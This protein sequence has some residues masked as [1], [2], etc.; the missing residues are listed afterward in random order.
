MPLMVMADDDA[1]TRLL[2]K[3]ASAHGA[4]LA[5]PIAIWANKP[6]DPAIKM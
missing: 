4:A 3:E 6:A 2:V 1:E 5:D